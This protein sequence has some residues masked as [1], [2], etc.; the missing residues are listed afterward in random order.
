MVARAIGTWVLAH[1][2]YPAA[3]DM[4]ELEARIM[5][6]L[7][8]LNERERYKVRFDAE[9]HVVDGWG[10]RLRLRMVRADG[11]RAPYFFYSVGANG[12]D[13]GGK[14]DDVMWWEPDDWQRDTK[15]REQGACHI[16]KP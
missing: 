11:E 16:G 1:H 7:K 10:R 9:G 3:A 8:Q 5:P 13:E 6:L 12:V 15:A 2:E 14:G 4:D